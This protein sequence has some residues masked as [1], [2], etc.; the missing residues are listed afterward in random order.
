MTTPPKAFMNWSGGKDSALAL[1]AVL[2]RGALTVVGLLTTVNEA[3][4][5]VS[6]HGVRE[7]LLEQ[8]AQSIGL[9][10]IKV[11]I[12]EQVSMAEYD[13]IMHRYLEPLAAAGVTHAIFGDIFLDDLRRY[14]EERLAEVGL[15]GIFPLW[16]IPTTQLAQ[17]FCDQGF[18]ALT[19][20]VNEKVLDDR[21]VGQEM[22]AAFFASLPAGVDVCGENGEYHSFVYDGPI[23]Q[24]PIGCQ[25]G[26]KVRRTLGAANDTFDTTFWYADLLPSL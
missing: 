11:T 20:C 3:Y 19:V 17:Q 9:P 15:T 1:H 14:R 5:R 10:L 25:V 22:D 13:A 16:Q 21:F 18:R 4:G 12:P 7:E 2:Q 26:E 8:Q 23:F 6:M 24:H